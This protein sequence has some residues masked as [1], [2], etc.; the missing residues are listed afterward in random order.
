MLTPSESPILPCGT[1]GDSSFRCGVPTMLALL[2]VGLLSPLSQAFPS[3]CLW[4]GLVFHPVDYQC[5][6][7]FL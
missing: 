4:V 1:R 6:A 3:F 2:W 7:D 5:R